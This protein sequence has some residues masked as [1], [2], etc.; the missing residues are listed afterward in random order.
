MIFSY[1]TKIKKPRE[2]VIDAF[3]DVE[4]MKTSHKGFVD[5]KLISGKPNEVDTKYKLI[6]KNFEMTETILSNDLPNSFSGLYVHKHMTN[7]MHSYFESINANETHFSSTIEYTE[8][9]GTFIKIVAKLFP[10][11]FKKQ[12]KAWLY[13]FKD[14]VENL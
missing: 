6:F 2:V 1:S 12:G 10:N 5:K 3:L 4:C 11:M 8:F 7:T 13:R 9:N 14:Y